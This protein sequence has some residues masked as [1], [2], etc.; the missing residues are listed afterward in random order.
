MTESGATVESD[1]LPATSFSMTGLAVGQ[2]PSLSSWSVLSGIVSHSPV[3]QY[4][5][6]S[7]VEKII[8]HQKYDDRSHDYDIALMK[9]E[10]PLN[11]SD[12]VRPVCLPQY[13]QDIPAG[14]ECWVSGWGHTHPDNIYL[15]K[16]R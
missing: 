2:S 9:L 4:A 7:A 1:L 15:A 6:S 14:S 12:S 10:K 8:Y 13:E 11:Y 3:R 5:S 16:S